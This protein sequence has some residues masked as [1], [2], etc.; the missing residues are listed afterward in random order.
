MARNFSRSGFRPAVRSAKR[1]VQWVGTLESSVTQT[2]ISAASTKL[3]MLEFSA[4]NLA[5]FAPFTI[6]RTR[7]LL[8]VQ[9]DQIA[10]TEEQIGAFGIGVVSEQAATTGVTALPGP[11]TDPDWTGWL[12]WIPFLLQLKFQS[13][14]GFDQ[15][16]IFQ[17][18]VDSKAMRKVG[19]D[20]SIVV[21]AET[22]TNSDGCQVGA[23]IRMLFKLH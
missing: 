13:G 12:Y 4:A 7:G 15:H 23:N 10:A 18:P 14:V 2:V 11:M 5:A 1:K 9:S 6:A 21:M 3:F 8:T 16:T 22:G 20:E 19:P 17:I